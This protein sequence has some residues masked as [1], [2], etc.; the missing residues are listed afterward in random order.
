[1]LKNWEFQIYLHLSARFLGI[2]RILD[3]TIKCTNSRSS[4]CKLISRCENNPY[5]EKPLED[6]SII[7][8]CTISRRRFLSNPKSLSKCDAECAL[9]KMIGIMRTKQYK[10]MRNRSFWY[11]YCVKEKKFLMLWIIWKN[12]VKINQMIG[13]WIRLYPCIHSLYCM[14]DWW[15]K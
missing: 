14:G 3:N 8:L 11:F 15:D 4:P 6:H 9:R 10:I 2:F 13:V 1:M 12:I 7:A 5:Y